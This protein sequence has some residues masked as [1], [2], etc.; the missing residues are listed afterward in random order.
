MG[1]MAL[2]ILYGCEAPD[3]PRGDQEDDDS[4]AYQLVRRFEQAKGISWASKGPHV[5]V[6]S[7]GGKELLGV[8]VAVGGSGEDGA[9]YFVEK[10]MPLDQVAAMHAKAIARAKKLW[11]RFAVY[12]ARK[13]GITLSAATLWLTPCEVP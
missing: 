12:V 6:E 7:E 11:D 13:E 5:R 2:G 1:Q 10:C 9:T 8:W 4:G 3:I